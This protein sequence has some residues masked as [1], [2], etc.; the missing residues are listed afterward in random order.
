MLIVIGIKIVALPQVPLYGSRKHVILPLSYTEVTSST[1]L[2]FGSYCVD[3][4]DMSITAISLVLNW[5]QINMER[6]FNLV[7][8]VT[9]LL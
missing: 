2:Q 7:N 4:L 3:T 8:T 6:D 1:F 9:S 5:V